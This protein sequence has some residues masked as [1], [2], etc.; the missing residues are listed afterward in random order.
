V[1]NQLYNPRSHLHKKFVQYWR[2]IARTFKGNPYVIA[3]ELINEPFV[4]NAIR[5][6]LLLLP[7]LAERIKFQQFYDNVVTA[8][9]Q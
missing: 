7:T 2:K 6:P 4:G 5:N 3:Y 8:I 1:F 9:R